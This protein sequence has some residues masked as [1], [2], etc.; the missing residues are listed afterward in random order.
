MVFKRLQRRTLFSPVNWVIAYHSK[1]LEKKVSLKGLI[2]VFDLRTKNRLEVLDVHDQHGGKNM[3]NR[4]LDWFI[5]ED[6]I[7]RIECSRRICIDLS[8]S[9][10]S[11]FLRKIRIAFPIH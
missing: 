5:T 2:N 11:S 4:K 1:F 8:W 9:V 6:T 10:D 7:F 3:L